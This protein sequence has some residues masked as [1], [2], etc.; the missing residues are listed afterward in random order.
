MGGGSFIGLTG[1]AID[2]DVSPKR[3]QASRDMATGMKAAGRFIEITVIKNFIIQ[4]AGPV[5]TNQFSVG[6]ST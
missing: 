1:D 5:N 2:R 4:R 3:Y 6:R